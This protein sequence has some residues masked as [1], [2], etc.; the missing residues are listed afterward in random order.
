MAS[1]SAAKL[2]VAEKKA[3]L[4]E[5]QKRKILDHEI[6]SFKKIAP[7]NIDIMI[8]QCPRFDNLLAIHDS[9]ARFEDGD[10]ISI[11]E[12][13]R[14]A[15]TMVE[16]M[17]KAKEIIAAMDLDSIMAENFSNPMD[18]LIP[19]KDPESWHDAV[20]QAILFSAIRPFGEQVDG[21]V[22][23]VRQKADEIGYGQKPE[24]TEDE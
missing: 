7:M 10:Y 16:M 9:F 11:E 19:N 5:E 21:L 24:E 6:D 8:D 20:T 17:E 18:E 12:A 23:K 14:I 2:K 13:K 3:D 22:G 4:T 1:K 15:D